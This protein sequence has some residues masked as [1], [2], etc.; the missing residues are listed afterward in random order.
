MVLVYYLLRVSKARVRA[1]LS[2]T[3]KMIGVA[4]AQSLSVSSYLPLSSADIVAGCVKPD[5]SINA[6]KHPHN[7]EKSFG[8]V[9]QL[10]EGLVAVGVPRT[11]RE[12]RDYSSTLGV[13]LHFI[14]DYFCLA[15]NNVQL[16]PLMAHVAYEFALHQ[17]SWRTDFM[18]KALMS[19]AATKTHPLTSVAMLKEHIEAMHAGYLITPPSMD[20]DIH[21]A[22]TVS[23]MVAH[24][25]VNMTLATGQNRAAV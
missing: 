6:I 20:N 23:T 2:G 21:Y 13:T 17:E 5:F 16:S 12:S 19:A 18:G 4:V 3:H 22:L 24:T 25:I 1:V 9:M 7:K 11:G 8:Y 14:S 10:I 15:H